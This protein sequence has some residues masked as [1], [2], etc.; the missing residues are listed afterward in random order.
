ML[1]SLISFILTFIIFFAPFAFGTVHLWSE[2]VLEA[3]ILLLL[4]LYILKSVK[5]G[6]LGYRK[7]VLNIFFFF[8]TAS[9]LI[10]LSFKI[11]KYHYDTYLALRLAVAYFA[12]S[13][14]IVNILQ[15]KRDIDNI[16]F[17]IALAGF[18]MSILGILQC[19][20]G[21]NKI[22]WIKEFYGSTFF[23]AFIN[24]NYFACYISVISLLTLGNL[25]ANISETKRITRDLSPKQLFLTLLDI[26]LMKK[27]LFT[28]FLVTVMITALFLSRSRGGI[29]A[30]SAA[31]IFLTT[32]AFLKKYPRKIAWVLVLGLSITYLL[33]NWLGL[34]K[35]MN[36]LNTIFAYDSYGRIDIYQDSL[37]IFKDYPLMGIG[38]GAFS[39]VFPVY[40]SGPVLNFY[41]YLHSDILQFLIETGII[42]FSILF[43]LFSIF[44]LRLIAETKA[45]S[46]SYKYYAGLGLISA[47]FYLAL[48]TS[49]D[50]GLHSGAISSLFIISMAIALAVVHLSPA[51]GGMKIKMESRRLLTINSRRLK[52]LFYFVSLIIFVFLS[53]VLLKPL[54]AYIIAE[55]A[56]GLSAFD[57]AIRLDPE[58][59]D[60]WFK[61]YKFIVGQ[62]EKGKITAGAAYAKAR[63][64]IE[65]AAELNPYKTNYIIAKGK[66][67]L[68]HK[69][70]EKACL[71][72]KKASLMEPYN[73]IV[74]MT[75]AY[76]LLRESIYEEDPSRKAALLK[77]GLVYYSMAT[78]LGRGTV[79]LWTI[80]QDESSY[81]IFKEALRKEGIDVY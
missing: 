22:Y 80:M 61:Y 27:V 6:V 17:K 60:I 14:V 42:G 40:R 30:F 37:K 55:K 78:Y 74:L 77:K 79:T 34:D 68:F 46:S 8:L 51:E 16:V 44:I 9:I 23:G 35:V 15:N 12:L 66:L 33:L 81:N 52:A 48:H 11:T 13:F 36:E 76:A 1:N 45:T 56:T 21:T 70:Y 28:I 75:Y 25:L 2:T 58:N 39:N 20:T 71:L 31:F 53:F 18:F 29:L 41:R 65:K 5:E 57:A 62:Y 59:D 72:F 49:I 47:F 24:S 50:F 38:L 19:V 73:P 63:L 3:S 67:E 54:L 26:A 32:S 64:A 4:F 43:V 69:D 10:Q 7:N